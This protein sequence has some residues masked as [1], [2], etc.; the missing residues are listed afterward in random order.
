MIV[1]EFTWLDMSHPQVFRTKS[2]QSTPSARLSSR[3]TNSYG[4]FASNDNVNKV[5]CL[6]IKL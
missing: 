4:A 3:L 2:E 1:S 6:R 5:T